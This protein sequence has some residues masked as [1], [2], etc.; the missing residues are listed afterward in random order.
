MWMSLLGDCGQLLA[1]D[2]SRHDDV[3]N[4]QIDR[5]VLVQS[6][7]SRVCLGSCRRVGMHAT[8]DR[9]PPVRG[10][11]EGNFTSRMLEGL[12][13]VRGLVEPRKGIGSG[14]ADWPT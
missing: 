12:W 9:L 3:G 10:A 11:V 14:K 7:P 6:P 1:V 8:R 4:E 5:V 2:V 13:G